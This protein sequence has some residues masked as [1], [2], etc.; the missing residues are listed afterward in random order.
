MKKEDIVMGVFSLIA[1]YTLALV[2]YVVG[3]YWGLLA[4]W[5]T[6]KKFNLAIVTMVSTIF[7]IFFISICLVELH[8]KL[9]GEVKE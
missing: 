2:L 8:K 1:F 4:D 5:V 7:L 9:Y 6:F 3:N